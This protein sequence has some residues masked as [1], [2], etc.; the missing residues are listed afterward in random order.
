MKNNFLKLISAGVLAFTLGATAVDAKP[1]LIADKLPHLTG[2]V[3]I[4]WDDEDLALTAKQKEALLVIKKSTM[5]G[6]KALA[7]KIYALE[8]E[9]VKASQA[10]AKPETLKAKVDEIAALRAK[11]TMIHLDCIY[12]TRAILTKEQLYIV[13]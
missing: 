6:A 5:G 9:V 1:F 2:M 12:N 3:K 4:L 11:A 13:E 7:K 8:D 10:G